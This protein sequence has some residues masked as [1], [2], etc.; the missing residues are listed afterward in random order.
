MKFPSVYPL[1]IPRSHN[2]MRMIAIVSSMSVLLA[3]ARGA[4]STRPRPSTSNGCAV[5]AERAHR[6]S[7]AALVV[8]CFLLIGW[9]STP[10][11]A[12][13]STEAQPADPT[14]TGKQVASFLT[15]AAIGF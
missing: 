11:A 14:S 4:A 15:G 10:A 5:I 1:T 8:L 6:I 13:E 3:A 2:T 9:G 12:Q 7:A